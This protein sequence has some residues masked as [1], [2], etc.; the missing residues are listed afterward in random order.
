VFKPNAKSEDELGNAVIGATMFSF[1]H[2]AGHGFINL[3]DLP[4]VG[5]EEDSVDQ[6]AT[7]TLIAMGD[8]GVAMAMSGAYWFQLQAKAG[9]HQT[10]FWDEHGFDGQRFYNIMCLI[11]GS[12]PGKYGQFVSSGALPEDRAKRC[13]DE[14][15]KI[16]RAWEKLLSPY[17]TNG[18]AANIDYKPSVPTSEA[19]KTTAK[20]PWGDSAS[21]DSTPTT[22]APPPEAAPEH[23]IT[24]EQVATRAAELIG[25]EAEERARSMSAEEIESLKATLEAQLPAAMQQILAECAKAN[26]S[27]PSRQCVLDATSL[28]VAMKCN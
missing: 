13:P 11:Y 1:Y 2:E 20:D 28:A 14:Y 4:A 18:A 7:L 19:P 12:N 10:P 26:W 3:L 17:V 15:T 16:N 8:Q 27:D 6:L 22:S 21:G 9:G 24:C 23:A 5:R 25:A